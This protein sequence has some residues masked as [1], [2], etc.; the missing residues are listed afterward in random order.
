[1]KSFLGL[2]LATTFT[3]SCHSPMN[4][5]ILKNDDN[6]DLSKNELKFSKSKLE[7]KT[8]WLVGPNGNI[9][10]N[11][12]LLVFIYKDGELSSLQKEN[13]LHFYATMPS[14]GHP[15]EDAGFFEEVQTGIYINKNI[16]YNMEGDW[17]NELWIMD[18]EFNILDKV[19]WLIFF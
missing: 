9:K 14:M 19:T 2:I 5:R 1:M 15:M 12:Q 18:Q 16:K 3:A 7:V 13:S 17:K 6:K 8:Q 4:H 11:N 10:K